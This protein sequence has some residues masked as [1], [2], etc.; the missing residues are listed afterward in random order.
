MS[1]PL[2]ATQHYLR[3]RCVYDSLSP[4]MQRRALTLIDSHSAQILTGA[5]LPVPRRTHLRVQ[6]LRGNPIG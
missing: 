1:S 4:A 6:V 5:V 2:S 3:A